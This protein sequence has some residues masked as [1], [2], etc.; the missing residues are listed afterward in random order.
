L[1]PEFSIIEGFLAHLGGKSSEYIAAA[2]LCYNN[3]GPLTRVGGRT[4]RMASLNVAWDRRTNLG[5]LLW[6]LDNKPD[7]IKPLHTPTNRRAEDRLASLMQQIGRVP[8]GAANL[9]VVATPPPVVPTQ[10]QPSIL[11]PSATQQT[12]VPQHSTITSP[13]AVSPP[14][15]QPP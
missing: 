2:L 3:I 4:R 10:S 7:E 12:A 5:D 13:A 15:L 14:M 11:P 1:H 9:P 6:N 8:L